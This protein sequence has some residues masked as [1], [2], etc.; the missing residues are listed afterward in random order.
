MVAILLLPFFI[1]WYAWAKSGWSKG[2]KIGA[3]VG[4]VII[5]IIAMASSPKT[6]P[7]TQQTAQNNP[8]ETKKVD[9]P[10]QVVF[11]FDVPALLGKNIDE[12]RQTLGQPTDGALIEPTA[13]QQELGATEVWDNTFEKDSQPL[14]VTFNPTSRDVIDYFI[15]TDDPSGATK[16]KKKLLEVGNLKEGASNYSVEFVTA[17]NDPSVYTGVKVTAK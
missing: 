7:N 1:I 2:V 9:E 6:E 17:I 4:A 13:R 15:S 8:T 11:I 12:V 5:I 16:D 3:T 14:L 10:V